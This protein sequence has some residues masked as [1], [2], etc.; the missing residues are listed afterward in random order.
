MAGAIRFDDDDGGGGIRRSKCV[1]RLGRGKDGDD[2][3]A[4]GAYGCKGASQITA[5]EAGQKYAQTNEF[6]YLAW[7]YRYTEHAELAVEIE[8]C[9]RLASTCCFRIYSK[10]LHYCP[11]ASLKLA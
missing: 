6:V 7:R 11:R 3:H 4:R 2:V 8:R 5:E 1:W 9:I 10:E